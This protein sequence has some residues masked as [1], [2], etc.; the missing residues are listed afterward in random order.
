MK[1]IK[2]GNERFR[3][4]KM[5]G[6][7]GEGE[8]YALQGRPGL[9]VKIYHSNLRVKREEK[10]RAMVGANL[11][12]K[13]ELVAY[14]GEVATDLNGE[15]LGFV[16][17]LVLGYRPLHELYSPKSR[18][19]HFPNADFRF[20]VH[21]A[22]NVANAIGNVHHTGCIIGDLNHSGVLIAEDA[23]IAL[24]D[25]D[26][27]QFSLNGQLYPCVVGVPEFTPP[28]LH[29]KKLS[30]VSRTLEH[31]NFGM[32]VAIFQL[33]FM[34]RHPYAGRY[35]GPDLSLGDAIAQNRFA[36][37]LKRQAETQTRPPPGA[38]TLDVFPEPVVRAFEDAF[39]T[40]PDAR[41]NARRWVQALSFLKGSLNRC[42]KVKTHYYPSTA[43]ECVWCKLATNSG[44]DMFPDVAAVDANFQF[45][46]QT[47]ERAI[48]EIIAFRFPTVAN[49]L[50]Q[51][52]KPVGASD[53][54][55]EARSAARGRAFF[56]VLL[57]IGSGAGFV[58]ATPL[59]FLWIGL[60]I[61]G[62]NTFSE[63]N[64]RLK[65]FEDAFKDADERVQREL[66]EFL[67]RNGFAE[68]M[69]VRASLDVAIS[70]YKSHDNSLAREISAMKVTRE[71]RQRQAYL[72]QFYIRR[73]NISGIGPAKT[74]T[75]VSFGIETAADVSHSA[76]VR[77]PGFGDALANKLLAWR[78]AHEA[79]F[80]YDAKPNSQDISDERSLRGK[81]AADKVKLESTIQSGLVTLRNAKV[82]LE[83]LP[84]RANGDRSLQDALSARAQAEYDLL[85][86][87][88]KVPTST[89]S[90]VVTQPAVS[91]PPG[92][93]RGTGNTVSLPNST[94]TSAIPSCPHCGSSMVRRTARRGMRSGRQFW[95]CSRYPRCKGTRN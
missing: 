40:I 93:S 22:L 90:M 53:L 1:E 15:F 87:G 66:S 47:T 12:I 55:R 72:D 67:R 23:T 28:E 56:G 30:A 88:A 45:D 83:A 25:A 70:A 5:I 21:A 63:K 13:S 33:L 79:R 58:F 35:N 34:N 92:I 62:W 24:I 50:P 16:M 57:M 42:G 44:L 65:K 49:L 2:I 69:K 91:S 26:S 76:I 39:G 60:A 27:F 9:A 85:E 78:R 11:A 20:M 6:K 31:D 74:A 8:I 68:V 84:A 52:P 29:G 75:L 18:R 81:F 89:V 4:A 32:A 86:L 7:G 41:P 73:A 43:G 82:Q 17:R 14:P 94:V 19:Q 54:L 10:I 3:I 37:S 36:F 51:I 61:W 46:S 71:A 38:V 95:G 59:W 80:R 64:I 48:A 77:V